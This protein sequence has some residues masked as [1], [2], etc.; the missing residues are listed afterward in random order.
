MS[1][2]ICGIARVWMW[3]GTGS[4]GDFQQGSDRTPVACGGKGSRSQVYIH[5][6]GLT[7]AFSKR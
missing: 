1:D 2:T 3:R 4:L 7:N 6:L 5:N